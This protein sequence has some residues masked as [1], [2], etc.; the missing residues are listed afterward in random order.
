MASTPTIF[1]SRSA[2][3]LQYVLEKRNNN[4][5]LLRLLAALAVIYGHAYSISPSGE[6]RDFI[7]KV[8]AFE[9][10]GSLAVKF[11]FLLSGLVV[12]NSVIS[13]PSLGRFAVSRSLRLFPALIVCVC[14]CTF[15]LGPATTSL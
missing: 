10:S 13:N 7:Q 3:K 2:M 11:F 1:D 12:T 5:D 4:F 9:T 15:A 14:V 6:K 8:L